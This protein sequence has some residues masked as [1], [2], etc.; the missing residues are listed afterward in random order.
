MQTLSKRKHTKHHPCRHYCV[1]LLA[2]I[3]SVGVA[4]AQTVGGFIMFSGIPSVPASC[5]LEY[6][7]KMYSNLIQMLDQVKSH[8]LLMS[9]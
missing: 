5:S 7:E 2:V 6:L 8:L 4:L 1:C 3:A 9:L